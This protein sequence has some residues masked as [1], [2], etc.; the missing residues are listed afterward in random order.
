MEH[1]CSLLMRLGGKP[2]VNRI[3][4][5]LYGRVL[6]HDRLGGFFEGLDVNEVIKRHQKFLYCLL[7]DEKLVQ[8]AQLRRIH[9][10][11]VRRQGLGHEHFDIM[12]EL[13]DEAMIEAG[14]D[15]LLRNH[16]LNRMETTREHITANQP[17][18]KET[19]MTSRILTL[20]YGA[21]A[22]A[23]GMASLVYIG[24][25]LVDLFVPNALDAAAQGDFVTG[26]VIDLFLIGVFGLQ[27]SGMAR[28]AFKRRWTRVIPE[29]IERSTYVLVSGLATIGL[30]Y[31]WQPLGGV[32]WDIQST[33]G[34]VIV[35]TLYGLGWALLVVSTFWINHF[36]LFGLR[37]VWLYFRGRSYTPLPFQTPGMYRF[38][39]H[40]LYL[41]WFTVIWAA[42]VM[43]ISHLLFA[44]MVSLYIFMAIQ[45]EEHDLSESL[46]EY[47]RYK[48][49]TPMLIPDLGL[50][51]S[52]EPQQQSA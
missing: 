47:R 38:V 51:S 13:L 36:D 44:M 1:K 43:T 29:Q 21:I 11:L 23:I 3:C 40:P 50:P 17:R 45:W 35:C 16:V 19:T 10:P 12:K 46:P 20:A 22:Y 6:L 32:V 52:R 8:L 49:R 24:L 14:I 31:F 39:R 27:H 37:Q 42:P 5:A 28:P 33:V 7:D 25:W 30:C 41:G 18:K 26:L 48:S 4:D 34:L 2:A 9:E 15:A